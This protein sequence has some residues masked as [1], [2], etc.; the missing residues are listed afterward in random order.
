MAD[1]AFHRDRAGAEAWRLIE[2]HWK[3]VSI[4]DG[5]IVFLDGFEK[6]PVTARHLFAVWRCDSE[7]CNGGF[8]QFFSNSTG[9]LA[10]EALEGFQAAGLDECA[11]LAEAAIGKFGHPFPRD[12]EA[13][14]AALRSIQLPGEKREEWDPFYDLDG[15]YYAAKKRESFYQKL[16]DFARRH[17]R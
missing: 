1:A 10:P 15:R 8:H 9:V 12:R 4:Y 7:V 6:L 17:A 16:D 3:A 2:P 5:P 13:R 14:R 11:K